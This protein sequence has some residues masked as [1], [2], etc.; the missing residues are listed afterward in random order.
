MTSALAEEMALM[1]NLEG[2]LCVC[3]S[4]PWRDLL[5][6]FLSEKHVPYDQ[7]QC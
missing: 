5:Q 3:H 1:G 6:G 4:L 2:D 7:L